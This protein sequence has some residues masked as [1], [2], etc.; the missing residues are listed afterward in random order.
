MSFC[1]AMKKKLSKSLR[2]AKCKSIRVCVKCYDMI[3]YINWTIYRS[4]TEKTKYVSDQ[5]SCCNLKI[6]FGAITV[7]TRKNL[8]KEW[9][10]KRFQLPAEMISQKR[11]QKVSAMFLDQSMKSFQLGRC[12]IMYYFNVCNPH[13]NYHREINRQQEKS[14]PTRI[15]TCFKVVKN[16]TKK[17]CWT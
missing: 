16:H 17:C 6:I 14:T 7:K 8:F 11:R 10:W 15:W 13:R 1:L 9:I 2:K 3:T 4:E 5:S 12:L